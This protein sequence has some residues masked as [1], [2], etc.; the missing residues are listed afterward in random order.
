[1]PYNNSFGSLSLVYGSK[2]VT[3]SEHWLFVRHYTGRPRCSRQAKIMRAYLQGFGQ[4]SDKGTSKYLLVGL[5]KLARR[6]SA[7]LGSCKNVRVVGGVVK[8]ALI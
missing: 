8:T 2:S 1:M 4:R 7:Y 6:L 3:K 5:P